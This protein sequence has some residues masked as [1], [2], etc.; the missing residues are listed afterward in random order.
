MD[1]NAIEDAW[2]LLYDEA[3]AEI[4]A[5]QTNSNGELVVIE[6]SPGTYRIAVSAD[7]FEAHTESVLLGSGELKHINIYL[8]PLSDDPDDPDDPINPFGNI[9]GYS[10]SMLIGVLGLSSFG[11]VLSLKKRRLT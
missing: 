4:Y 6:L 10:L 8:S 11:L 7:G 9:P 1:S 2:I 3:E 5:G